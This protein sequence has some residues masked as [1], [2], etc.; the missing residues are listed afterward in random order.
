MVLS[1]PNNNVRKQ[2]YEFM[3][4]EYQARDGILISTVCW[5]YSTIWLTM[6]IGVNHWNSLLTPTRRTLPFA[7]PSKASEIS[8]ASFTAYL[9]VNAYYLLAPELELNHGFCD[10]FLMPDLLRYTKWHTVTS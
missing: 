9:S 3:L 4:E 8:K 2:Y 1:I 6:V 7:V 5:T 10:L